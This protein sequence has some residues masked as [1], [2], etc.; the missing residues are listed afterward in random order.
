MPPFAARIAQAPAPPRSSTGIPFSTEVPESGS[1]V[2]S[3]ASTL[4]FA[5]GR[6]AATLHARARR[7]VAPAVRQA[8]DAGQDR[9]GDLDRRHHARPPSSARARAPPSASASA[10]GVLAGAPAACSGRGPSRAS[11]GCASRSCSSAGGGG[12]PARSAGARRVE[13]TPRGASRSASSSCGRQLDLPARRAQHL[14]QARLR[15][16]RDRCRAAPPRARRARGP[17]RAPKRV[18]VGAR[19]QR[20]VDQ[21][22]G[23][24]ARRERGEDLLGVAA[25]RSASPSRRRRPARAAG[26]R[27]RRARS[28]RPSAPGPSRMPSSRSRISHSV[29]RARRQREDRRRVARGVAHRELREGDVEVALLERRRARA[30]SRPR[31]ASSRS[32]RCRR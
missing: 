3:S 4:L 30:G 29:M 19:A 21:A 32:G 18:A 23:T 2:N 7:V 24:A 9:V 13:S 26:S 14:G 31:G 12:R 10:R 22:L 8:D 25:V 27:A 5:P 17:R 6:C 20:E 28:C 16:G 1:S 15:A 11:A